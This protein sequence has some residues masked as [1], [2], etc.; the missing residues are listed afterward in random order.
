M[1]CVD[2]KVGAS[3]EGGIDACERFTATL[4]VLSRELSSVARRRSPALVRSLRAMHRIQAALRRPLRIGVV[5][6]SNTGK[7]TLTNLLLGV[8]VLPTLQI[9]N[10][11]VPT[12]IRYGE[13]VSVACVLDD[14]RIV[15]MAPDT[16]LP[17]A[18]RAVEVQLPLAPLR[19]C[20][21]ADFPG[22]LDPLLGYDDIDICKHR[23]DVAVWCTFSTQAW[24]ES[25]RAAWLRLPAATRQCELLA[26]TNMDRLKDDQTAKVQAR[27]EKVARSDFRDFAFLSSAKAQLAINSDGVVTDHESWETSG[28]AALHHIVGQFLRDLRLDRLRKAQAL[29]S[30]IAEKALQNLST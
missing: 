29:T 22:V 12:L 23:V 9:A 2:E 8:A 17:T 5:G 24:K 7:S 4:D 1:S 26:V 16:R 28:A 20:E 3:F 6:E 25:E 27:L 18:M 15:P 10:T 19:T 11:R 30:R 14:G 21:I 13:T